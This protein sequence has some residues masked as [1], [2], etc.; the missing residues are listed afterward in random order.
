MRPSGAEVGGD[1][2]DV[3]PL[4]GDSVALVIGDVEGHDVVAAGLMDQ[5]RS[6]VRGYALEGHPPAVVL[7][8]A[9]RF[10]LTLGADRLVTLVMVH[11]HPSDHIAVVAS[12]GHLPALLLGPEGSVTTLEN[13]PAP[14]LGA[15]SAPTWRETTVHTPYDSTLLLY[16][17]GLVERPGRS[18][19]EGMLALNAAVTGLG[20]GVGVGVGQLVATVIRLGQ[21]DGFDDRAVL[22]ARVV[23]PSAHGRRGRRRLPARPASVPIARWFVVDLLRQW[24]VDGDEQDTTT[25]LLSEVITNACRHSED[26]V[27]LTVLLLDNAIRVEVG[28]TSHRMPILHTADEDETSGRGLELVEMPVQQLGRRVGRTR[29]GGLV[30]DLHEPHPVG[31]TASGPVERRTAGI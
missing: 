7:D 24:G 16:T 26:D 1:W 17:D 3:I 25:L 9:N 11:L 10:L 6:V 23:A 8:Y 12:A 29:K 4:A 14:P 5:V 31:V 2:Y 15:D 19:T 30:R 18:L 27:E 20:V 28:D 22:A 21:E 13:Q